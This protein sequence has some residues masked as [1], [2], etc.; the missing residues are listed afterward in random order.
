MNTFS[1]RIVLIMVYLWL[2]SMIHFIDTFWIRFIMIS[3]THVK[4][5]EKIINY[6]L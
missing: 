4:I 1:N 3:M 5:S 2:L 6:K